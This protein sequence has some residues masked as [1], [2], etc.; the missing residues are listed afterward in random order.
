M[1]G[2]ASPVAV[3]DPGPLLRQLTRTPPGPLVQALLVIMRP[4]A[5]E[6]CAGLQGS[7]CV[8]SAVNAAAA[9]LILHNNLG[10][11][12]MDLVLCKVRLAVFVI[13]RVAG[14][15]CVHGKVGS[16][17]YDITLLPKSFYQRKMP[18]AALIKVWRQAQRV[19]QWLLALKNTAAMDGLEQAGEGGLEQVR[20]ARD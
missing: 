19:R 10:G 13:N 9:A 18:S 11:E 6:A 14:A 17:V 5:P 2:C 12:A 8:N 7:P 3:R 4:H 15:K 16:T 20:V 1:P